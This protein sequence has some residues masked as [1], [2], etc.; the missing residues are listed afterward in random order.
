MPS[1]RVIVVGSSNTDLVVRCGKLPA[2][3]ETVLGSDLLTFSGGK[4]ANQAVAAA[5]AGAKTLFIGAFGDDAFGAARKKDLQRERV[6]C[7]GCVTKKGVSS[8]VALIGIGG[9]GNGAKAENQII[10]APGANARLTPADVKRAMPKVSDEDVVLCSLEVPLETVAAA[11]EIG[12]RAGAL[13]ILNPAPYPPRGLPSKIL[14]YTSVLIPNEGEFEALVGKTNAA[15]PKLLKLMDETTPHVIVTQGAKGVSYFY[16]YYET[17]RGRYEE[18]EKKRDDDEVLMRRSKNGG[19]EI[20]GPLGKAKL[21]VER[22][23]APKVKPVDTVGAGDCFNG[24][25]AAYLAKHQY[26][27]DD[28]IRFAVAAGAL[29]VTRQGAQ[30]GMP[31]RAEILRMMARV[32]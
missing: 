31:R 15:Q 23:A 6:D 27:F 18:Y 8:G 20:L 24:T 1:G 16:Q 26:Q 5:R 30:A 11:L 21:A 19:V 22:T 28:A 12:S 13:T 4:G 2:P 14:L 10:V 29:K 7:S 25:L 17:P 32:K 3:G 9:S